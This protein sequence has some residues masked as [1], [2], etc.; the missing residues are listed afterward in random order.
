MTLVRS[1]STALFCL[2]LAG[3]P[4]GGNGGGDESSSESEE[5]VMPPPRP[6]GQRVHASAFAAPFVVKLSLSHFQKNENFTFLLL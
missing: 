3:C 1:M 5:A 2:F 6:G 4:S